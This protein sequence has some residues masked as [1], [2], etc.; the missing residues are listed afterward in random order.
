MTTLTG[1]RLGA[2]SVPPRRPAEIV[3]PL[4]L[5]ALLTGM[6][7]LA[8]LFPA[9]D[10]RRVPG[11]RC[12]LIPTDAISRIVREPVRLEP[13]SGNV[14][15]YVARDAHGAFESV[16][17]IALAARRTGASVAPDGTPFV[18]VARDRHAA[19]AVAAAILSGGRADSR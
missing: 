12:S 18:V 2:A 14:C 1:G 3:R 5:L 9:R 7:A 8:V 11:L 13:S 19:A 10:D 6:I 17:V 16:S 15:R 4:V